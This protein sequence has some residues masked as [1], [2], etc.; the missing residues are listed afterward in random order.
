MG[1]FECPQFVASFCWVFYHQLEIAALKIS[2][3][4][5][6]SVGVKEL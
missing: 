3:G 6:V 4:V 2:V 5:K 1:N